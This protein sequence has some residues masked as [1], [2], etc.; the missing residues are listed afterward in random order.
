[1]IRVD[2]IITYTRAFHPKI[3]E[4]SRL[5]SVTLE[6]FKLTKSKTGEEVRTCLFSCK[7]LS[8]PRKVEMVFEGPFNTKA[9]VYCSCSCPYFLYTNEVALKSKQSSKIN[10]SNGAFPKMRNPGMVPSTCKHVL[11]ILRTKIFERRT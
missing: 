5:V 8:G 11:A 2:Q 7:H 4:N 10:Y 3:I 1:M 9:L 6:D